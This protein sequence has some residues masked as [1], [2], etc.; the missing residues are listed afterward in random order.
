MQDKFLYK[1]AN[2]IVSEKTD[3]DKLCVVFPTKRAGLYLKKYLSGILQK[4]F[5]P[6][7]IL[8]IQDFIESH[9]DLILADNLVLVYELFEQYKEIY[10]KD[11]VFE[12]FYSF[13]NLLIND[14]NNIDK[15]LTHTE[16]LFGLIKNYKEIDFKFT[17]PLEDEEALKEFFK[18]YDNYLSNSKN[19]FFKEFW[20]KIDDLYNSYKARLTA[21]NIGYEG[22]IYRNFVD[23]ISESG[24]ENK[25]E[26][27]IFAGFNYL[28][29][30]E[31]AIFRYY[32]EKNIAEFYFDADSYYYSND[33]IKN[34]E[35]GGFI[36]KDVNIL[37]LNSKNLKWIDNNF[38][39]G[40]KNI[41]VYSVASD[42]GQSKLASQL[43]NEKKYDAGSTVL[44]LSDENLLMPVLNSLPESCK[45][46]NVSMSYP[47]YLTPVKSFINDIISLHKNKKY[48]DSIIHFN[49]E[50]FQKI[51]LQPY[52]K[53]LNTEVIY[54]IK[55]NITKN[56]LFYISYNEVKSFFTK[57]K[58]DLSI[59]ELLFAEIKSVSDI[60]NL[61]K[62]IFTE[63]I[64]NLKK[65]EINSIEIEFLYKTILCLNNLGDILKKNQYE[66]DYTAFANLITELIYNETVPFTGEPLKGLQIMG[67]FESRLIDFE[68]VIILSAN[69]GK[70]PP[71]PSHQSIIPYNLRK[72]FGMTLPEDMEKNYAYLFYRL[73]QKSKNINL[74]YNSDL[75]SESKEK[76]RYIYQIEYELSRNSNITIKNES[77]IFEDKYVEPGEITVEKSDSIL[78]GMQKYDFDYPDT[79]EDKKYFS[80]TS[81]NK[82]INCPLQFYFK[83][84]IELE[85]PETLA[86]DVDAGLFGTLLHNA[87]QELYSKAQEQN[88]EVTEDY[89]NSLKAKIDDLINKILTQKFKNIEHKGRFILIKRTLKF[90]IDKILNMD[91]A[92]APFRIYALE[93]KIIQAVKIPGYDKPI[94]LKGAIDRIDY[95]DKIVRIIDYK[96]GEVKISK[97]PDEIYSNP[98]YS[99]EFQLMFYSYLLKNDDEL[100]KLLEGK[101]L[102]T[103]F[104]SMRYFANEAVISREEF[105][106]EDYKNASENITTILNNIFD[107]S[108]PFTQAT[109]M[110]RCK[111]CDFRII[112]HRLEEK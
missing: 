42:S 57:S 2:E 50:D 73:M 13:G 83:S 26:K 107:K 30:S 45:E 10:S 28:T 109:D 43:I 78:T 5:F 24:L 52:F 36:Q 103:G 54:N 77:A 59:F 39:T 87:M 86:L 74:L 110:K 69:E 16:R 68:N 34:H 81:L 72:A 98:D 51:I 85:E 102:R 108:I 58:V 20:N 89:I 18:N 33:N 19:D 106:D 35:A 105:S 31:L 79:N 15:A 49:T 46:F 37:R 12:K 48:F 84:I 29:K 22:M 71:M 47:L 8:S 94:S 95:T 1:L 14:F 96:T 32:K 65:Y 23:K 63:I 6:P 100:K 80:A 64:N 53:F 9:S 62:N 104:Y 25:F 91:I 101:S 97:T 67:L 21:K 66:M 76:S 88:I 75:S 61:I 27:I 11:F 90:Y 93:K 70:F 112:C 3:F 92:H 99:T 4:N 40:T 56:K 60:V 17:H 7:N 82:Y 38:E 41:S 111:Y 55:F 44:I